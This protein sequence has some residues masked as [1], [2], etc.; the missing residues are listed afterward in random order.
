MAG[1]DGGLRSNHGY[2]PNH[3]PPAREFGE[4]S[5]ADAAKTPRVHSQAP[6]RRSL[7]ASRI[8]ATRSHQESFEVQAGLKARTG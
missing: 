8:G 6:P 2:H 4:G 3:L 1:S 5:S 7:A